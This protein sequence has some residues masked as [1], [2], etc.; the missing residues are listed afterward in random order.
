M[1]LLTSC[2]VATLDIHMLRCCGTKCW[3]EVP[4]KYLWKHR[5]E[6]PSFIFCTLN[7]FLQCVVGLDSKPSYAVCKACVILPQE[8]LG[9]SPLQG[10]NKHRHWKIRGVLGG[11]PS[12]E[13]SV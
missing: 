12:V 2:S 9:G 3:H 7:V 8:A 4:A 6:K 1:V 10:S 5:D 11:L 13:V